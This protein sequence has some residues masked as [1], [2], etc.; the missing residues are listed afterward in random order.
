MFSLA[1]IT[2]SL[3]AGYAIVVGLISLAS[4]GLASAQPRFA[5]TDQRLRKTYKLLLMVLWFIFSAVGAYVATAI[6]SVASPRNAVVLL[7]AVLIVAVW[8][9]KTEARQ[10]GLISLLLVS[11]CI[12]AGATAGYLLEMRP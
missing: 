8:R 4:F 11:V 2:I 5:V 6:A 12:V 9:N 3:V 10:L 7:S 1:V